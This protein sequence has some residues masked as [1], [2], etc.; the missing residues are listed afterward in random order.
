MQN[1]SSFGPRLYNSIFKYEFET[2]QAREGLSEEKL[3]EYKDIFSFF[4][5][6]CREKIIFLILTELLIS[7]TVGGRSPQWSLA[8]CCCKCSTPKLEIVMD[9]WCARLVG[10]LVRE[11][12]RSWWARST[13]YYRLIMLGPVPPWWDCWAILQFGFTKLGWHNPP[14]PIQAMVKS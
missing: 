4:D 9:R 2:S 6:W 14:S 3:A 11:N 8:R 1:I 10:L 7:G 12:Y 13:K 5:R